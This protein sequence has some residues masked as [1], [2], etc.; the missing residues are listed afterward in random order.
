MTLIL[1]KCNKHTG[2][3]KKRNVNYGWD[4]GTIVVIESYYLSGIM[5]V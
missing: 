5:L 3:L 1:T 4:D 2:I